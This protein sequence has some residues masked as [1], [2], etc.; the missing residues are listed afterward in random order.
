[1][2]SNV[3]IWCAVIGVVIGS[4][5][6]SA[7]KPRE[8]GF[9]SDYS[10]LEAVSDVSYSYMAPGNPLGR[11]SKFIIDPVAIEFYAGSK[12]EEKEAKGKITDEDIRK[13]KTYMHDAIVAAIEDR[14]EVVSRPGMGVVRVRTAIT[15]LKKSGVVMNIIPVGKIVGSGLG[16]A[17]LEGEL[18]DS[19]SNK[20][21]GAV[22][23]S[24]LGKRFSLAGYSTWGDAKAVMDGWAKRFR[25]R[26]DEAHGY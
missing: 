26:L 2:K 7:K 20:Q 24:Q 17:T 13:F 12:G 14:Y 25:K 15:D 8:V 6:C 22:V 19:Q 18:L 23:E 1:M 11:Y 4:F 3:L 5:G 21:L 10:K 9:L 16:G